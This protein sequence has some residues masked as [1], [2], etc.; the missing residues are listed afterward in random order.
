MIGCRVLPDPMK[1]HIATNA[2]RH[3][4]PT[5]VG[6]ASLAVILSACS[7]L[8]PQADTRSEW[9]KTTTVAAPKGQ[10]FLPEFIADP[11]EPMNRGIWAFNKGLLF[12]VIQP[13]GRVYRTVVPKVA[14]TSITDFTR[15]I[16]YPGRVL[17]HALQGR[18]AGA[19]DETK[20]FLCN[21]TVGVGGFYD[22]ASRWNIPKS[23]AGFG[24]T[25]GTWGW[26]PS[27]FLVLPLL[28]PSDDRS[29]V[30][31]VADSAA[32]P[33][34]YQFPYRYG[35]YLSNVNTIAGVSEEAARLV[36]AESDSYSLTKYAWSYLSK[37][38]KPDWRVKGPVDVATLET[39]A[40]AAVRCQDPEFPTRAQDIAVPIPTTGRKLKISYWLQ[41]GNAPL[42]YISPGLSSHRLSLATLAVAEHLYQNGFSVVAT[43][44]V[45]HPDFMENASTSAL[46]GYLTADRDD[47]HVALTAMD[48]ALAKKY[49][50][51]FGKRALLGCSMGAFLTARIAADENQAAAG[52]IKFDRYL[53]INTPVSLQ[54]GAVSVDQFYQA[55]LAWPVAERQQNLNNLFLKGA[56][57]YSQVSTDKP[58]LIFNAI[59]SKYII[60][61]SFR[62]SLRDILYST[63]SRKDLGVLSTPLSAWRREPN[64]Q[65]LMKYTFSEYFLK[66]MVPYFKSRGVSLNELRRSGDLKLEERKLQ[67]QTKLRVI[68]NRNDFLL[69]TKDI[70]WLEST[71]GAARLKVFPSGGHL[72]NLTSPPVQKAILK[73]LEDLK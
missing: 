4:L 48:A 63:Q 44:S 33:W 70:S 20:R 45:F 30:G 2:R 19:G 18:W 49:P 73:A 37:D 3:R 26:H 42:V 69:S 27:T 54:Y 71:F 51:R 22:V 15:N 57:A 8:P 43:T 60:G 64:Y 16:T 10:A 66:F 11:L 47:L 52:L 41:K 28:G 46:P 21:T 1:S 67:Q 25:F 35:S 17:N 24:Q 38:Q 13:S 29:A 6:L 7:T 59:E 34:N 12:G 68:T 5:V 23:E 40:A 53:A 72:G 55:P 65:E 36:A 61:L 58:K 14:R 56:K 50:G 62:L 39:L 32:E 9:Q 31:R